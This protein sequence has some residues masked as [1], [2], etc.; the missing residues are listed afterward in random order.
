MLDF[1]RI[2]LTT[3][4]TTGIIG[5]FVVVA[6]FVGVFIVITRRRIYVAERVR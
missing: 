1:D 5:G 4:S 3:S 6:V 2:R